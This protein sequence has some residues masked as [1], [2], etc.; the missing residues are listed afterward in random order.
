M[1]VR[2]IDEGN[3]NIDVDLITLERENGTFLAKINL[4]PS[5]S[6]RIG[7]VR[8]EEAK[9]KV[10]VKRKLNLQPVASTSKYKESPTRKF[11]FLN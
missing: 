4:L 10:P 3:V 7:Y 11:G 1:I 6:G 5:D 2:N 9:R 8:V